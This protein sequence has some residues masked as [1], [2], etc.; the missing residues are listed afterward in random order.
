MDPSEHHKKEGVRSSVEIF[1]A[2]AVACCTVGSSKKTFPMSICTENS[3]LGCKTIDL[4]QKYCSLSMSC[5]ALFMKF[6]FHYTLSAAHFI[7]K[8]IRYFLCNGRKTREYFSMKYVPKL[9]CASN[10]NFCFY[11]HVHQEPWDCHSYYLLILNYLQKA[12]EKKFPRN[13]CVVLERLI[14]VALRSE[15][16]T[17][18]DISSQYQKFQLLLCAAEV[19]LHCGNYFKCI[20]HAK[21]AVEKQLPDNYL[22]F[23][24]LLL[25]RAYAVEDNYSGLHEEYIRCVELK[26]DYHIGWICLKF[27]ESRYKLHSDS[28][29]LALAF[30]E[31]GKEI[32]TSS[33]M[34]IAM[35]NLVQGLSAVWDGEFIVAEESLAQACSLAGGESCL[36]L[37]HGIIC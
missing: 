33:N 32:R 30:Q 37:S 24:H 19:S 28:S 3:T 12:R 11:R 25:C 5:W 21:S 2:G 18:E 8:G 31:C 1:G 34:W 13:L 10:F 14:S 6:Y 22:F 36:F 7:D 17:K 29:S 20:M 9:F 23:A 27:L 4:L 16:Y 26:T 35:Y 15:L